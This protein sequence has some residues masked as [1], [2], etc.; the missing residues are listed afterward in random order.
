M[1]GFVA[2]RVEIPV[3]L[4]PDWSRYWFT[5]V[6][7]GNGKP[8]EAEEQYRRSLEITEAGAEGDE[9]SREAA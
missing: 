8:D 7:R 6:L 4:S 3:A 5:S 2:E 9:E 1:L